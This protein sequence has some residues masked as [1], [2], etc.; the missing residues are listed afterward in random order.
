MFLVFMRIVPIQGM[1]KKAAS[2][3]LALLPCSR[4]TLY[5]PRVKMAAALLDRFF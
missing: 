3:V 1:L 5:A 4:T 2:G